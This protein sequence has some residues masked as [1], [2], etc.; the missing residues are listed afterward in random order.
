MSIVKIKGRSRMGPPFYCD[1]DGLTLYFTMPM[2][3]S[4][5]N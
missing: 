4:S 5:I 2:D 3:A 1:T